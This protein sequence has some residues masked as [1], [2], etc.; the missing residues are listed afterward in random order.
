MPAAS[1]RIFIKSLIVH[2]FKHQTVSSTL[3]TERQQECCESILQEA[4]HAATSSRCRQ[5]APE[6]DLILQKQKTFN[7]AS[8]A[9]YPLKMQNSLLDARFS[10]KYKKP[11]V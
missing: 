9:K 10:Q 8:R 1:R 5:N 7:P 3:P 2:I 6:E 4:K 11:S